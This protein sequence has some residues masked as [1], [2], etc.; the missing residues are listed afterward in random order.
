MHVQM[1]SLSQ[2][3]GANKPFLLETKQF[4]LA[5]ATVLVLLVDW[6][7]ASPSLASSLNISCPA[8]GGVV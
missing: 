7:P 1:R 8:T 6:N 2:E 3:E 4:L 5:V